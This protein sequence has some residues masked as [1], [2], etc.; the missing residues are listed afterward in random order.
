MERDRDWRISRCIRFLSGLQRRIRN[1]VIYSVTPQAGRFVLWSF[2]AISGRLAPNRCQR[3]WHLAQAAKYSTSSFDT[4]GCDPT[5]QK[6]QFV[7]MG[8][9]FGHVTFNHIA[10]EGLIRLPD[11]NRHFI[12]KRMKLAIL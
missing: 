7:L 2:C 5:L 4:E 1:E 10:G 6:M 8:G 9:F 12:G 3:G 11:T